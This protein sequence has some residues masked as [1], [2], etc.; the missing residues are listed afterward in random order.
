MLPMTFLLGLLTGNIIYFLWSFKGCCSL[1]VSGTE[2]V[3]LGIYRVPFDRFWWDFQ[4]ES[5]RLEWV[6]EGK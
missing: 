6:K 5:T 3:F 1:V 4:K 2:N